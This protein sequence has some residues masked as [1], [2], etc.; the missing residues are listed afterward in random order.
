VKGIL[1]AC[2]LFLAT[3]AFADQLASTTEVFCSDQVVV[4]AR[5]NEGT[6]ED[7]RLRMAAP[8]DEEDAMRLRVTVS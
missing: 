5:V 6:S 7:C 8:C 1:A 4:V 2:F 3:P